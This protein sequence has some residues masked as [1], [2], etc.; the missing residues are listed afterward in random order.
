[1]LE[2]FPSGRLFNNL[3]LVASATGLYSFSE[4]TGA[5]LESP[6][7]VMEGD[8]FNGPVATKLDV[9]WTDTT[10]EGGEIAS[11]C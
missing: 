7:S 11:V 9:V 2:L 1:M 6:T 10:V 8:T 3:A 5:L 4:I